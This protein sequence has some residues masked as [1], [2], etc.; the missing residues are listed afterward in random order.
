[1]VFI[2]NYSVEYGF[3]VNGIVNIIIC[4]GSN[5]FGGEVFLIICFGLVIDG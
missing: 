3:M 2:N 4:S 5:E 1:M